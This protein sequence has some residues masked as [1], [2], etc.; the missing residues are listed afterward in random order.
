MQKSS[1]RIRGVLKCN[2][3]PTLVP[4]C[5]LTYVVGQVFNQLTGQ[6]VYDYN[7]QEYDT[8]VDEQ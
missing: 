5:R 1:S 6:R 4:L 8:I 3:S 7:I 2:V